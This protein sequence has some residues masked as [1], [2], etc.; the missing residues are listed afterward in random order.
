PSKFTG[1]KSRPVEQVSWEDVQEFIK[2]LNTRE[3]GMAF[4]RLPTEA[5]WEYAARAGSS[6]AYSFG[7][8]ASDLG[9]HAWHDG[10]AG[11]QTHPVG[12]KQPNAWGLY[13]MHGNVWE[14]VQDWHS[15]Y[16]SGPVVD[17]TGPASGALRVY[18]GGGWY[19]VA[20]DGRSAIRGHGAP[21][22][23]RGSL[24]F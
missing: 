1:D 8:N 16:T 5:E 14:W 24:G 13:D 3:R 2:R 19:V 21:G 22:L 15:V 11:Q 7:N 10:N 18:R 23:R 9:R 17:P 20:R 4:Y 12:Q 6:T